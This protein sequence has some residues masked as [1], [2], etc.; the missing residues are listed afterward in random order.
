MIILT[1]STNDATKRILSEELRFLIL[2]RPRFTTPVFG[3][4]ER[5]SRE[6]WEF[7]IR[8]NSQED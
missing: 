1:E 2:R 7:D 3:M 5:M 8:G 6:V 4:E